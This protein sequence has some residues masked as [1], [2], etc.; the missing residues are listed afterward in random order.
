ML[1]TPFVEMSGLATE[2]H[3]AYRIY[4]YVALFGMQLVLALLRG[5]RISLRIVVTPVV[6]A[7]LW[8]CLSLTW[9]T[10]VE[11][12]AKR[13]VLLS[14]IYL[15]IVSSVCGLG[16]K[17]SLEIVRIVLAILLAI[18]LLAVF[19]VP[20]VGTQAWHDFHLWRGVMADKN[21]ACMVCG[22][23][24]LLFAIDREAVPLPLGV[25]VVGGAAVGLYQA[26]SRTTMITVVIA[27]AVGAAIAG[28]GPARWQ[29]FRAHR[30]T[31]TKALWLGFGV[32]IAVLV[33]LTLQQEIL[34]SFTDDATALSRRGSIWRPMVQFYLDH[35]MLG[36]G[37]GAYW[38][39]AVN[40]EARSAYSNQAWLRNVDQGHNG[41]LDLLV[42]TGLPGLAIGLAAVFVWPCSRL[43]AMAAVE[44]RRA[45]LVFA[46]IVFFLIE[47][48]AETSLLADDAIGNL[49]LL[50]AVA[51]VHRF[52][53]TTDTRKGR[54]RRSP[55]VVEA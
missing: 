13:V 46:L 38:D 5:W 16:Y 11:L 33:A 27:L 18:N 17:R 28:V 23:T 12:A 43:A 21:I 7:L 36:S 37:Y 49:F 50:F 4:G 54:R 52:E 2:D 9:A 45:A 29:A 42:Q 22:V 20:E 41:Y 48:L 55:A 25:L 34:L 47:N 26:W 14:L 51:Q 19:F 6:A 3:K 31:T 8:F 1:S 53:I 15:A 35:P 40:A 39:A 44:P 24:I 10:Q 32:A 30:T